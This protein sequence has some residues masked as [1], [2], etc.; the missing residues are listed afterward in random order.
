MFSVCQVKDMGYPDFYFS[1]HYIFLKM[2][3]AFNVCSI[4]SSALQTRFFMNAN[5]MDPEQTDPKGAAS[6]RS[7]LKYIYHMTS[8]LGVI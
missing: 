2:L 6:S 1:C 8:H 7:I 3:S 5:T 4:D